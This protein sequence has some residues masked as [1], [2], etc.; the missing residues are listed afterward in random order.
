MAEVTFFLPLLQLIN[1]VTRFSD[2]GGSK[3]EI[4]SYIPTRRQSPI[5]VVTGLN[6]EQLR[7]CDERRAP[8]HYAKLPTALV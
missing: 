2:P 5:P 8:Y 3:A 6:V 7:S 1:A 4:L